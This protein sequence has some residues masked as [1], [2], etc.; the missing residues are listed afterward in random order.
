MNYE[1]T[2][3]IR[4]A[5]DLHHEVWKARHDGIRLP[6]GWDLTD[7]TERDPDVERIARDITFNVAD[8]L[9]HMVTHPDYHRAEYASAEAYDATVAYLA[10]LYHQCRCWPDAVIDVRTA[11]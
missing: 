11:Y 4:N 7:L 9:A 5:L 3:T 8:A 6:T 2:L 10:A 1:T